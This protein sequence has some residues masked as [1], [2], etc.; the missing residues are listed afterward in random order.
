MRRYGLYVLASVAVT[1]PARAW[2]A[3]W[4]L[5]CFQVLLAS[6][7]ALHLFAKG[8]SAVLLDVYPLAWGA[9]RNGTSPFKV[10]LD[11][12]AQVYARLSAHY[13]ARPLRADFP[14]CAPPARRLAWDNFPAQTAVDTVMGVGPLL[15]GC[16]GE[17]NG[18]VTAGTVERAI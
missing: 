14:P 12:A 2:V 1:Q 11:Q 3:F 17:A 16:C 8:F 10:P 5:S 7:A 18:T 4:A 6:P 9:P 13:L 15:C